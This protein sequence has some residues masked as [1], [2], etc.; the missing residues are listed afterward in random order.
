MAGAFAPALARKAPPPYLPVFA[1]HSGF[2]VNLHHRL[3]RDAAFRRSAPHGGMIISGV[4]TLDDA[5]RHRWFYA[6][7]VY[8]ALAYTLDLAT[9]ALERIKNELGAADDAQSLDRAAIPHDLKRA[10]AGA[11]PVYRKLFWHDDDTK[12]RDWVIEAQTHVRSLGPQIAT[13]FSTS[14]RTPWPFGPYRVDMVRFANPFGAYTTLDPTRIVVASELELNAGRVSLEVL[15]REAARSIVLPDRGPFGR[16]LLTE[17]A[18]EHT[19]PPDDFWRALLFYTAARFTSDAY[20]ATGEPAY[21]PYVVLAELFTRLWPEYREPLFVRWQKY[22][23][24]NVTD[25]AATKTKGKKKN[26][27]LD[28]AVADVLADITATA[29][30]LTGDP[31]VIDPSR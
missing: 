9:P 16:A 24:G 4:E 23:E 2:Y 13:R 21:I 7:H 3:Y 8:D 20:N 5:D 17:A 27:I 12:N 18:R 6:I 29:R 19:Q 30:K 26:G 22:L 25:L 15:Y 28:A 1:F 31:C 14:F 10:L 11:A